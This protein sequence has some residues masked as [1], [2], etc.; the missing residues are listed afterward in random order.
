MHS[1]LTL[2]MFSAVFPQFAG[3]GEHASVTDIVILGLTF[4]LLQFA[5]GC[6]CCYFG[7]RIKHVLQNPRRRMLLQRV[8]ALLLLGVAFLLARGFPTG[9]VG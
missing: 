5:S 4:L 6:L 2:F 8:T 7:Q 1:A 3:A 9:R